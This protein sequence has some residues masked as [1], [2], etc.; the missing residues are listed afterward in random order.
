MLVLLA[1]SLVSASVTP[2]CENGPYVWST[3]KDTNA[4]IGTALNFRRPSFALAELLGA[5]WVGTLRNA[6]DRFGN[7]ALQDAAALLGVEDPNCTTADLNRL[8]RPGDRRF[9]TYPFLSSL[10]R[11][12]P[13]HALDRNSVVVVDTERGRGSM[14]PLWITCA[15]SYT[16]R[17]HVMLAAFER[18]VQAK[19]ADATWVGV[20]FR[21]GDTR[22]GSVELPAHSALVRT[23]ASLLTFA[24]VTK[25]YAANRT[26]LFTEDLEQA[27]LSLFQNIVGRPVEVQTDSRK[28]ADTLA[29]MAQ[30][31][32][33][34]GGSS[35]FFKLGARLCIFADQPCT[36]VTSKPAEVTRHLGSEIAYNVSSL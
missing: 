20:H 14:P 17:S 10:C 8:Y 35:S 33:L 4:G 5:Q 13:L 21:W 3:L 11:T 2:P 12:T 18:G 24:N 25:R 28:W 9:V 6:H 19:P 36:V 27:H 29:L 23:G 7:N 31:T 26:F 16:F 22:A 32:V 34:I 1:W 30:C 15:F